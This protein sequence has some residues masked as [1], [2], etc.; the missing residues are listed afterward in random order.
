LEID[1]NILEENAVSILKVET[2]IGTSETTRRNKSEDRD[3][4]THPIENLKIYTEQDVILRSQREEICTACGKKV[5][6]N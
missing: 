4:N 2:L 6:G 1:N 5:V 3:L